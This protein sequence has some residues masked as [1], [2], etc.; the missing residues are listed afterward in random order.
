M[1]RSAM[2]F[3]RA[4]RIG[5][6]MIRMVGA[7]EDGVEGRGELAA[8]VADQEPEPVDAVA[9]F[10]EQVAG[11]LGDPVPGRVRDDPGEVHATAV[12]LD[13]NEDVEAAQKRGVDV[14]EVD[15]EVRLYEI[16]SPTA[17]G[18]TWVSRPFPR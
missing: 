9:E 3:A 5:V 12:V 2:A 18:A 4:A 6:R 14:G 17:Y 13:H 15:R 8:S 7:G 16:P 11:L 10:H 1:K